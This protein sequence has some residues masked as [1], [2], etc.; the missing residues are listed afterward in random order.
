PHLLGEGPWQIPYLRDVGK[1][2]LHGSDR[3]A[4]APAYVLTL[5]VAIA[6]L[7]VVIGLYGGGLWWR[8]PGGADRAEWFRSVRA[9][10]QAWKT[11]TPIPWVRTRSPSTPS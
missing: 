11:K 8:R 2:K 10:I 7:G 5:I 3:S 6:A 1:P 4:R 9:S